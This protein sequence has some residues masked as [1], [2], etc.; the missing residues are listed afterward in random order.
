MFGSSILTSLAKIMSGMKGASRAEREIIHGRWLADRDT[1]EIWGWETPAGR[2]RA[3]RR[4]QLIIAGAGL[5]EGQRALEIGCGTG[6]FTEI[7]ATTGAEIVALDISPEL[8]ERARARKLP[9]DRVT[10]AAKRFEDCDADVTF[11]A[12]IGSSVLHHLDLDAAIRR[13]KVLL[14][15]GGRISFAEPNLLN[16][17]VYLERKFH[18]LP[19]FSYTSPDETAFVRWRLARQLREAGFQDIVIQPF[20]WLHPS[21]PEPL[22]GAVRSLGRVLEAVPLLREF[23]G[24]VCISARTRE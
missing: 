10:F 8:L 3:K 7:F 21:T 18:Y 5:R 6:L 14:K 1:E 15:P 9:Q 20:D 12:L 2:L 24:S 4:A 17:Q 13:M 19:V 11:D 16:P 23:S 22:I